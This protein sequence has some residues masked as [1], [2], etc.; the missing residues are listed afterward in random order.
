MQKL[1]KTRKIRK[2]R[3]DKK[4]TQNVAQT[5]I[6]YEVYIGQKKLKEY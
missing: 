1:E 4:N 3:P 5:T 2:S 6:F